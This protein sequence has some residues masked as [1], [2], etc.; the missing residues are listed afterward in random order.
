M[1]TRST[2]ILL[3]LIAA[4]STMFGQDAKYQRLFPFDNEKFKERLNEYS[5]IELDTLA[6]IQG[7]IASNFNKNYSMRWF[8]VKEEDMEQ[9]PN[10]TI[11]KDYSISLFPEWFFW[12][13]F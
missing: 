12:F 2:I 6:E 13:V 11:R 1:T 9:M 3:M 8:K 7:V 4:T 5:S 10:M